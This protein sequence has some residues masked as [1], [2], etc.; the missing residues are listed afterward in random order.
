MIVAKTGYGAGRADLGVPNVLRLVTG[1]LTEA[2]T[3]NAATLIT[4]VVDKIDGAA[5]AEML[6]KLLDAGA[7]DAWVAPISKARGTEALELKV[8][9]SPDNEENL[10]NAIFAIA[11]VADLLVSRQPRRR[12]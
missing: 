10:I 9:A 11:S 6:E 1:E 12:R 4:A 7:T 8:L 5:G 3:D 2:T